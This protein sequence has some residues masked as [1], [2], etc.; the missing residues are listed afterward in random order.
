M[1]V[2]VENVHVPLRYLRNADRVALVQ[3]R[4]KVLIMMDETQNGAVLFLAGG[5]RET[6]SYEIRTSLTGCW[7]ERGVKV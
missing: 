4:A 3:R 6:R 2:Y 7:Q 5:V 1:R